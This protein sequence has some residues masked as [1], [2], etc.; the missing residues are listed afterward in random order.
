MLKGSE[1]LSQIPSKTFFVCLYSIHECLFMGKFMLYIW[2]LSN[3]RHFIKWDFQNGR[4]NLKMFFFYLENIFKMILRIRMHQLNVSRC[5]FV[6]LLMVECWY[7][8]GIT[9][10]PLSCHPPVT[11]TIRTK[12]SLTC[13]SFWSAECLMEWQLWMEERTQRPGYRGYLEKG[14]TFD[15]ISHISLPTP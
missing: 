10:I 8:G 9:E 14:G 5:V 6:C 12:D 13:F 11:I 3:N 7:L 1:H 15:N 2:Y 4:G